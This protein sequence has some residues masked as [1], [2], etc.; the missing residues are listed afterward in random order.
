M[1][2][3]S[4]SQRLVAAVVAG[5][6]LAALPAVAGAHVHLVSTSPLGGATLDDP[7]AEVTLTFDGELD[8]EASGFT[9]HG[10]DGEEIGSGEVDLGV[11]DRN[12]VSG[13]VTITEPGVYSVD[14]SV[15]GTDGH[16]IT[17]SFSFGYATD[18]EV[19][20]DEGDGHGPEN[21]DTAMPTGRAPAPLTVAGL[22]LIALAGVA[23]IRRVIVR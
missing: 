14:W 19:P 4:A 3:P 11:A 21:P 13:A 18:E 6:M 17:G 7:P 10:P 20:D 15:L 23:S 8:P 12:I 16:E 2:A 5:L 9:V 1:R 22:L